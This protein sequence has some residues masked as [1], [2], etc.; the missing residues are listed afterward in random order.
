VSEI[1]R[2]DD[3]ASTVYLGEMPAWAAAE[4]PGLYHS[5]YSTAE[6]FRIFDEVTAICAC[7]LDDPRHIV[8]FTHAGSSA[9]VLNQLF[10]I[11]AASLGR[12]CRAV[13]R[14]LPRVHRIRFNGSRLDP[15]LLDL[16]TR[17]VAH[18]EDYVVALPGDYSAYVATLGS[19]T[20]KNVRKHARRLATAFA[21]RQILVYERSEIPGA[22]VHALAELNRKRMVSKGE[23]GLLTPAAEA[24][25]LAFGRLYGFCLAFALGDRIIAG[26][27]GTLVGHDY[28]G[29]VQTFD[30][31]YPE[32]HLGTLCTLETM[33]ECIKRGVRRYHL[34]WGHYEYKTRLGCE[35]QALC[36]FV[37]YRT[38][39][40]RIIHIDDAV[41][42]WRW[43]WR[44]SK[45][46]GHLRSAQSQVGRLG[47]RLRRH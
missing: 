40:T 33:R 42:A 6:Y 45:W 47:A 3:L 27:L 20:R 28:Y 10:D 7:I 35:P 1:I 26:T 14:S 46:A 11:D 12:V 32:Y 38:A 29:D 19:A 24:R 8:A 21:E 4:L 9:V 37:A 36:A 30:P 13:F 18:S 31:D 22:L 15:I 43:R 2:Y 39:A 34:L 5:M 17:V 44:R 23:V 16:P 41:R 25:I